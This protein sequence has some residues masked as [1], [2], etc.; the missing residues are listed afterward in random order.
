[1]MASSC[2]TRSCT[3]VHGLRSSMF[4]LFWRCRLSSRPALS[5]AVPRCGQT[6][7]KVKPL[8]L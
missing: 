6:L 1:M 2:R 3:L 4:G 5:S 7:P 8:S